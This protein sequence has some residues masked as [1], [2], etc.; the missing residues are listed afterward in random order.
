M[1]NTHVRTSDGI[2]E[3]L[4]ALHCTSGLSFRDIARQDDFKGVPPGTLCAIYHGAEVPHKWRARFG[5]T[6]LLPAPACDKCGQVHV[7]RRCTQSNN[8]SARRW[9][10]CAGHAGGAWA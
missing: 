5:L 4:Y 8:T 3:R 2:K 7:S 10:R 9:V 6:P 1:K